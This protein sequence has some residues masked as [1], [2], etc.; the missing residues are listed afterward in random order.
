MGAIDIG[1]TLLDP[2]RHFVVQDVVD[3]VTRFVT[4]PLQTTLEEASLHPHSW[5]MFHNPD[6][7]RWEVLGPCDADDYL[8]L[9]VERL[10][11]YLI[12]TLSFPAHELEYKILLSC[13]D[14][15]WKVEGPVGWQVPLYLPATGTRVSSIPVSQTTLHWMSTQG[16]NLSSVLL[17]R[18]IVGQCQDNAFL[19][20]LHVAKLLFGDHPTWP[21]LIY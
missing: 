12:M 17:L 2:R 21:R 18:D 5:V 4:V 7:R 8:R 20:T 15:Q 19:W 14:E 13:N 9:V 16:I 3:M 10:D 1:G 11:F 6:K